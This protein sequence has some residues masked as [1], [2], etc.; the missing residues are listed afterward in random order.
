MRSRSGL[1]GLTIRPGRSG[2]AL[3]SRE[4]T[5]A[6]LN[7]PGLTPDRRMVRVPR[8]RFDGDIAIEPDGLCLGCYRTRAGF[9][10]GPRRPSWRRNARG[11]E[12]SEVLHEAAVVPGSIRLGRAGRLRRLAPERDSYGS[13]ASVS[14]ADRSDNAPYCLRAVHAPVATPTPNI[15]APNQGPVEPSGTRTISVSA[16][17]TESH[18]PALL[19]AEPSTN[20]MPWLQRIAF[21]VGCAVL[22]FPRRPRLL[23]DD[24]QAGWAAHSCAR[25]GSAFERFTR[26]RP[27]VRPVRP[28]STLQNSDHRGG[29]P[30][31]YRVPSRDP[32]SVPSSCRP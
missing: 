12:I 18:P 20:R 5:S 24:H 6:T 10:G 17:Q 1:P 15:P 23:C 21:L 19:Q 4:I 14:D 29:A 9:L 13:F 30:L 31:G 2:T 16:G 26:P 32:A 8:G 22:Q 28:P 3:S 11:V 25:R 7:S 27:E